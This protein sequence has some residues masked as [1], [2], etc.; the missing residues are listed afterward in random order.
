MTNPQ[1]RSQALRQLS[2]AIGVQLT[3]CSDVTHEM[4]D[5]FQNVAV[6]QQQWLSKGKMV[7]WK[8]DDTVADFLDQYVLAH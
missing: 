8:K 5:R 4:F 6:Y 7:E 1:T 3:E 2:E